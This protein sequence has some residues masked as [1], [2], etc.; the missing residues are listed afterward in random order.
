MT[1]FSGVRTKEFSLSD[2][3]LEWWEGGGN[4]RLSSDKFLIVS[5]LNRE[6]LIRQQAEKEF[7]NIPASYATQQVWC[8]MFGMESLPVIFL[9]LQPLLFAPLHR[10]ATIFSPPNY[11]PTLQL[12]TFNPGS[13][14]YVKGNSRSKNCSSFICLRW[15]FKKL[16]HKSGEHSDGA[17]H[18]WK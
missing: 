6:K 8:K 10:Q 13:H 15:C 14:S 4:D 1:L 9:Y 17:P 12:L 16:S 5:F 11:L 2:S 7:L 3:N 18:I